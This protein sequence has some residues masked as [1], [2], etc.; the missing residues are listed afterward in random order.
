MYYFARF[1]LFNFEKKMQHDNK[2]KQVAAKQK[3]I[4]ETNKHHFSE[5]QKISKT[6]YNK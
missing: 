6:T 4:P 3:K 1:T 5:K 2:S